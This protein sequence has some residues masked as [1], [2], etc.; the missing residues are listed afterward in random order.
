MLSS[1]SSW[2]PSSTA[3]LVAPYTTS[4]PESA[5]GSTVTAHHVASRECTRKKKRATR[6]ASTL[7][8]WSL[9]TTAAW[10]AGPRVCSH[11][12]TAVFKF[13]AA[14]RTDAGSRR[15]QG[16][17]CERVHWHAT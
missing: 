12:T 13:M 17:G 15:V 1:C 4:L 9:T 11:M 2:S 7:R 14:L 16:E 5:H 3:P 6:K 8:Y 10:H